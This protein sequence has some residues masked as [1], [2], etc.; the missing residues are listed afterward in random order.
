M[1]ELESKFYG[2]IDANGGN[3][4]TTTRYGGSQNILVTRTQIKAYVCPSDQK[5]LNLSIGPGITF[6][7]GL[8][9]DRC[10]RR[11]QASRALGELHAAQGHYPGARRLGRV[12][13]NSFF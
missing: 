10:R 3:T 11:A 2:A 9:R 6:H 1:S 4:D 8:G 7:S 13:H 5:T 12:P